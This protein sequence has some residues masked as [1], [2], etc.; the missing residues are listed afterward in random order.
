MRPTAALCI[1][2]LASTWAHAAQPAKSY[3]FS[4][5][6]SGMYE[7]RT[8]GHVLLSGSLWRVN[9]DPDSVDFIIHTSLIGGGPDGK[10]FAV[11][12]TNRTWYDPKSHRDLAEHNSIFTLNGAREA[13][14]IHVSLKSNGESDGTGP[15]APVNVIRFSYRFLADMGDA[16]IGGE[17]AGEIRVWSTLDPSRAPMLQPWSVVAIGTGFANV[18]EALQQLVRQLPG[19]PFKAEISV[20]RRLDGGAWYREEIQ[21]SI[22]PVAEG[23]ARDSDFIV[24]ADYAYREPVVGGPK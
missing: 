13:S 16:K 14:G 22:T 21:R 24:P 3:S 1:L 8:A 10:V 20:S 11:N 12:D 6:A 15:S 19:S 4:S 5:V 23:S 2:I 17:V 18:D 9:F 7:A